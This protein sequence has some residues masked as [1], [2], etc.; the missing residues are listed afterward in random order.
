MKKIR[1]ILTI[2]LVFCISFG[3]IFGFENRYFD[4]L[5][6]N[7]KEKFNKISV[8]IE[9]NMN[10]NFKPIFE[11]IPKSEKNTIITILNSALSLKILKSNNILTKAFLEEFRI[12]ILNFEETQIKT[13]YN[14]AYAENHEP[15]SIEE[16][17]KNAK[18]SYVLIDPFEK[19]QRE[20]ISKIK[21]NNNEVGC[22]ISIGTAE[23]WRDDFD[24]LEKYLVK[25]EWSEWEGEYFLKNINTEVIKIMQQRIDKL[26]FWGCDW[27]EFD[28]MDWV[29]DQ[30]YYKKY[31]GEVSEKEV[32]LYYQALCL[33]AKSE[34]LKCMAKNTLKGASFFDGV[35]YESY[36]D[37]KNWWNTEETKFF[38]GTGKLVIVNHYGEKNPQKVYKFYKDFYGENISFIA[39]DVKKEKYVHY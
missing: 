26:A 17:L 15:E 18:K 2:I 1:I 8:K 14:V 30:N 36:A 21:A 31:K 37:E 7:E 5:S 29:F 4:M 11:K 16:V 19:S 20:N 22:Y 28:N 10:N 12:K 6:I 39:E 32:V 38:L 23:K 27:V 34:K 9:Q 13:I 33:Y 3:Q 35:L 24:D 25:K